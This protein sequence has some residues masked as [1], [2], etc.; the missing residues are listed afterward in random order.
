[1]S[2]N[3]ANLVISICWV[4]LVVSFAVA[5]VRARVIRQ[6]GKAGLRRDNRSLLG[7]ILQ[8]F[9]MAFAVNITNPVHVIEWWRLGIASL[10]GPL[11]AMVAAAGP[12]QL[13]RHLR[14]QAVVTDDHEL[15][16]S[17]PYAIVRHPLYAGTMWLT[18]ATALVR[19]TWPQLIL[20]LVIYCVG[21][22]IRVR[23]EE[24]L[25][26]A[27]FPEAVLNYQRRVKA[28]IPLVR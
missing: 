17:G 3:T 24:A 10:I 15:V 22:E 19:T 20:G 7:L 13:G 11:G 26:S 23:V 21:T 1:M 14:G 12:L 8:G 5:S 6:G 4:V 18:V 28:Y 9:G 16:T 2:W 27:R 25:L